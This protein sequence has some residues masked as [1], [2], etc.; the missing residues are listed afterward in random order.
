MIKGGTL[1][2]T[3]LAGILIL[4]LMFITGSA[5]SSDI[6]YIN[7][8]IDRIDKSLETITSRITTDIATKQDIN[9]IMD[10]LKE[11]KADLKEH[12]E[13]GV[14]VDKEYGIAIAKLQVRLGIIGA[15]SGSGG[16]GAFFGIRSLVSR[17]K[18]GKKNGGGI[19]EK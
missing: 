10:E 18:N 15:I 11:I 9:R 16:T 19:N 3:A 2:S 8:N 1:V 4:L 5:L 17:R 7:K 13:E 14:R 6:D 12:K